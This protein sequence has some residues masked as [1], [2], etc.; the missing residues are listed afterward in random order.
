VGGAARLV[1]PT[2][3]AAFAAAIAEALRAPEREVLRRFAQKFSWEEIA[4]RHEALYEGL[5]RSP[6]D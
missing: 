2:D 3:P 6:G 5:L 4:A 1:D